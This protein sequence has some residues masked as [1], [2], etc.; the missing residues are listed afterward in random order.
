MT[1]IRVYPVSNPTSPNGRSFDNWLETEDFVLT[2]LHPDRWEI[3]AIEYPSDARRTDSADLMR[4]IR[5]SREIFNVV[6][7]L[8]DMDVQ[9]DEDWGDYTNDFYA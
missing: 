2:I 3:E 9:V 6:D 1:R 7:L 4:A 8:Y 5:D